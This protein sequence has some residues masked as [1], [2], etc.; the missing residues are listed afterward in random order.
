VYEVDLEVAPVEEF[1]SE[2]HSTRMQQQQN[3]L[4]A[5][6]KFP[7]TF[8]S[9]YLCWQY[10]FLQFRGWS[11]APWLIRLVSSSPKFQHYALLLL[12]HSS[13]QPYLPIL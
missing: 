12:V 8:D 11:E 9:P 7:I 5:A 1:S 6:F 2:Y 3:Y 4:E 10:S 13:F